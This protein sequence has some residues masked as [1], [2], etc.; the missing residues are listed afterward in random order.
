MWY[1]I[2]SALVVS[3]LIGI[4]V[5]TWVWLLRRMTSEERIQYRRHCAL[6][7]SVPYVLVC[8]PLGIG[9]PRCNHPPDHDRAKRPLAHE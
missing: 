2:C 3:V 1:V 5:H 7:D 8:N 9:G 6:Q 4:L